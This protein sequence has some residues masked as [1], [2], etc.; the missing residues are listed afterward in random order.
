VPDDRHPSSAMMYTHAAVTASRPRLLQ[1]AL[2]GDREHP[3]VPR[4]P[5]ELA[6]E[7]RAAV[8]TGA[9]SLHLHPYDEYRR[10]TLAAEPCAAT[11]RAVRAVCPGVSISLS[12]SATIEADPERRL[13]LIAA[14][15][16]LPDLVT[17]NRARFLRG[18]SVRGRLPPVRTAVVARCYGIH[19][20]RQPSN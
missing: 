10:E 8:D 4:M 15:M 1:A 13:A 14:W 5:E 19:R 12:T 20:P 2:N 7:A 18:I 11:L 16:E 6:A 17:A 9:C 3:A